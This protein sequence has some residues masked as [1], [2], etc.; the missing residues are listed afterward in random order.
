MNIPPL[1]G[2]KSRG[3]L[4]ATNISPLR[5]LYNELYASFNKQVPP[6]ELAEIETL[7]CYTQT[8]T[9]TLNDPVIRSP[10]GAKC[11]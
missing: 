10:I 3:H 1:R 6:M 8:V 5:G 9:V 11:L 7:C 2:S 4:N